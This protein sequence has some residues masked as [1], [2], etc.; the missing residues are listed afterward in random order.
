[1]QSIILLSKQLCQRGNTYLGLIKFIRVLLT[2][3][4]VANFHGVHSLLPAGLNERQIRK[5]KENIISS[6][7]IILDGN[8][9]LYLAGRP[10]RHIKFVSSRGELGNA[11]YLEDFFQSRWQV[12]ISKL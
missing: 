1:M 4:H 11:I 8:V 6:L 3:R 10:V 7:E 12:S 2:L 5:F 9:F